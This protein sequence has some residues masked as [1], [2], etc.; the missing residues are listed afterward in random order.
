MATTSMPKIEM[1]RDTFSSASRMVILLARGRA[2][3]ERVEG[4]MR[5]S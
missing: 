3:S 1:K 4:L 2:L 5:P